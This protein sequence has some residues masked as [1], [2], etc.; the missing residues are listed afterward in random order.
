MPE[1]RRLRGYDELAIHLMSLQ[2]LVTRILS[3]RQIVFRRIC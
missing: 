2:L 3:R 1:E